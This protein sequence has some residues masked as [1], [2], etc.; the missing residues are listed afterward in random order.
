MH[1]RNITKGTD[2]RKAGDLLEAALAYAGKG[3]RVVPLY[4]PEPGHSSGCDCRRRGCTSPAKHP[5]TLHGLHDATTD[6]EAIRRWWRLWPGANVGIT[7]GAGLVVLDVDPRHGG[8]Q[9]LHDLE[10]AHGWI[11][12]LTAR[13]GGG[14]LHLYL[15]GDLLARNGFLPGLDLKA[16]G[17]YVVAPPSLHASGHRYE[18]IAPEDL[19]ERPAPAPEWLRAIVAPPAMRPVAP[20]RTTHRD[21]LSPRYVAAAIERECMELASAPEGTRNDTLNRAAFALARFVESGADADAIEGALLA[22]ALHA[23]LP[24]REVRRTLASA[25]KAR[26]AA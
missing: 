24:E 14:G 25:F 15:A 11:R 13:T 22:A 16:A 20:L 10:E 9:S 26:A 5:R 17:G 21:N 4:S 8:D 3:W 12:T 6:A 7:T 18:W 23:G 2:S 19:P 1:D